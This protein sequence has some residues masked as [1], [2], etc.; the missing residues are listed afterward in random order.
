MKITEKNV[1]NPSSEPQVLP[2]PTPAVRKS[3]AYVAT[4]SC[5]TQN[6]QPDKAEEKLDSQERRDQE[7]QLKEAVKEVFDREGTGLVNA[8]QLRLLLG[9]LGNKLSKEE[10]GVISQ[11]E[12]KDGMVQYERLLTTIMFQ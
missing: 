8:Q 11:F 6:E 9:S 12:D 10:M 2:T 5:K 1:K 4:N 7:Y 3:K